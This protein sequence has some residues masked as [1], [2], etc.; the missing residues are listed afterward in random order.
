M[1]RLNHV[2]SFNT[3]AATI[4]RR[5]GWPWL[6]AR[7]S[8]LLP[9][10]LARGLPATCKGRPPAGAT[11]RKGRPPAGASATG[12]GQPIGAAASGAPARDGRQR[13]TRKGLLPAGGRRPQGWPPLGRAAVGLNVQHHRLRRGSG[14]GVGR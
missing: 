6:A 11:A 10:P 8:R 12:C 9:R 2:E 7:G 4:V 1:M 14:G 5:R 3:F 13:P